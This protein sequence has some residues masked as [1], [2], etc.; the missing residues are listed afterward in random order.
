MFGRESDRNTKA[1][2]SLTGHQVLLFTVLSLSHTQ[3]TC[4]DLHIKR[5]INYKTEMLILIEAEIIL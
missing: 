2:R 1:A 3:Y 4:F 5:T